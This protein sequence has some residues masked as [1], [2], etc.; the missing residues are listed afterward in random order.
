MSNM[1]YSGINIGNTPGLDLKAKSSSVKLRTSEARFESTSEAVILGKKRRRG[2]RGVFPYGPTVSARIIVGLNRG[3]EVPNKTGRCASAPANV[4]PETVDAYLLEARAL[5][6]TKAN[7]GVTRLYGKGWYRGEPEPAVAYD[8]T[9]TG[10][11]ASPKDF[12]ANMN[13]L[14]EGI[15]ERFCQDEVFII[16]DD[17]DKRATCSA[18]WM[19]PG[20]AKPPCHTGRSKGRR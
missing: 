13:R 16:H 17:G 20:K 1:K 10:D 12:Q 18:K 6:V 8:I 19:T 9:Y 15:G 11:E 7:V 3:N 2:L 4:T 14:A 5:Q